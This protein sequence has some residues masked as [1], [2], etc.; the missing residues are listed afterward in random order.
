MATNVLIVDSDEAFATILKEGLEAD[1]FYKATIATSGEEA[2]QAVVEKPFDMSIV[3]MGLS[4]IEGA[5][6]VRA[7]REAKPN[8][9]VM[10]IPLFGEELDSDAAA[11]DIQGVLTKPFF[12]GDLP[13]KIQ[14][15][16]ARPVRGVMPPS[17]GQVAVREAAAPPRRISPAARRRAF[18]DTELVPPPQLREQL[19]E[20]EAAPPPRRPGPAREE[21]SPVLSQAIAEAEVAPPPPEVEEKVEKEEKVA[22]KEI[23]PPSARL[24]ETSSALIEKLRQKSVD[25]DRH[26]TNLAFDLSAE[27]VLLTCATKLVAHAGNLSKEKSQ[28]LA[29]LVSE[30]FTSVAQVARLLG[31]PDGRFELSQNEGDEYSFYSRSVTNEIVLSIALRADTPPGTVR[32]ITKQTA[33]KLAQLVLE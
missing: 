7:I 25:V 8:M 14:E 3:D 15:A 26:L 20:R 16:L 17:P 19:R 22:E 23:A 21:V 6:L 2:L 28:E 30:S 18:A 1:K 9:R 13:Q 27:S 31:E 12:M 32:Y 11:L 24:P 29:A 5:T 33:D 4:D 10:L